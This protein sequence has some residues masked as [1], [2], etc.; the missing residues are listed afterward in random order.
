MAE[1]SFDYHLAI[2]GL[3]YLGWF[4]PGPESVL[5]SIVTIFDKARAAK[6][7]VL[8]AHVIHRT[9]LGGYEDLVLNTAAATPCYT[10]AP[11]PGSTGRPPSTYVDMNS[12]CSCSP[13]AGRP[14][15]YDEQHPGELGEYQ[16]ARASS[17]V[18]F[19]IVRVGS[20]P[21]TIAS[22]S[23]PN[24]PNGKSPDTPSALRVFQSP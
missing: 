24:F 12:A 11:R 15:T 10:R 5:A 23:D 2:L 19:N 17:E 21:L 4:V 1:Y 8:L 20:S 6:P 18:F 14:A 22:S 13:N 7:D 3:K 9:F 16:I